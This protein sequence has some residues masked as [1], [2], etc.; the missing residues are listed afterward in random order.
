VAE[1][2]W[3][4]PF[5]ASVEGPA[6]VISLPTAREQTSV[7]RVAAELGPAVV[8]SAPAARMTSDPDMAAK[9]RTR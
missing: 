6:K 4:L 9:V 1:P 7:P 8:T 5:T 2:C 3:W